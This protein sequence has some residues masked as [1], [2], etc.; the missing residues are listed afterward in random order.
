VAAGIPASLK[1]RGRRLRTFFKAA[2]A[3][4]LPPEIRAKTKHGFGLP[5]ATWLRTDPRLKAMMH[6]L[7]LS[8]QSVQ[9]G[10]VRRPAVERLVRLHAA[11]TGSS[12]YGTLLWNLMIL[13]LWHRA[14]R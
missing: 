4:L 10:Y 8:P 2:Y 14:S 3:D 1:M 5:V 11:D 7:V 13:E 9:R 12:L 6:D